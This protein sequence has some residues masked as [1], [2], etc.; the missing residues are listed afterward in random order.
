MLASAAAAAL[1]AIAPATAPAAGRCGEPTQR[2]WCDTSL[3]PD[4]RV[5]LLMAALT[6]D[7]RV[8]L[9]AGDDPFA[10]GGGDHT[11]TG[12]SDGIA[13]VGLRPTY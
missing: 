11:H 12:T 10:V 2:P 8:S 6:P 4:A 9:L 7:E 13:R 3:G 1:A 5:D